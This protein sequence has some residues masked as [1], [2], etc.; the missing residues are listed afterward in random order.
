MASL[1]DEAITE[2]KNSHVDLRGP[3]GRSGK[4]GA[5]FEFT[6]H[7]EIIYNKIQ[8][9][10]QSKTDEL[11]LKFSDL[12]I[13]EVESLT[14]PKGES[15]R[16]GK[17]GKDFDY[18]E[19]KDEIVS[20]ISKVITEN[21][22][23]YKLKFE[24]LSDD[25]VSKLRG[26][27]GQ[28]GKSGI[29]GED[30]KDFVFSEHKETI[31][32]SIKSFVSELEQSL[33]LKFSDLT[34][35]EKESLQGPR[36]SR[37][38]KGS[39][40]VFSEHED[41][42]NDT[43]RSTV[44]DI[45]DSLK[46]KFSDLSLEDISSLRGARGQRGK[47]GKSGKDGESIIGPM[48]MPGVEGKVG[49]R[50][51]DGRDAVAIDGADGKDAPIVI[52]VEV[53]KR[54]KKKLFF[55]FTYSDLTRV[56]TNAFSIPELGQAVNQFMAI[57]N[58]FNILEGGVTLG[59][60]TSLDFND[61]AFNITMVG[62]VAEITTTAAIAA[63]PGY[64]WGRQGS[65]IALT[66][67]LNNGVPSNKSGLPF[68]LIGGQGKEVTIAS[69]SLSTF[70]LGIYEHD[71]DENNLTLLD[72]LSF[73]NTARTQVFTTTFSITQGKQLATRV[74]TGSGDDVEVFL[75]IR[76]SAT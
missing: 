20:E 33:R 51:A 69:S 8:E 52:K 67:L 60:A 70:E 16:K 17:D 58:S 15:G 47:V 73:T 62:G 29:S 30:G 45:K 68:G 56:D 42:I 19:H 74:L 34:D 26:P 57:R 59:E 31:E 7:Q 54:G 4:D 66:W 2:H 35:E 3:R 61:D 48:G 1:V 6:D 71:G 28:R 55:R 9:F 22:D 76:G 38:A 65:S 40:F 12:T 21:T 75:T 39:D 27:R 10:V 49:P 53:L 41:K 72:T 32:G 23:S 44:S 24:D 5:G 37:G 13:E 11:K 25:D 14:G 63:T 64:S 50:G 43:I 46:L 18:A 36:G